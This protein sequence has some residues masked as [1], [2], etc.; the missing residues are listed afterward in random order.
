MVADPEKGIQRKNPGSHGPESGWWF[1]GKA[2]EGLA[3][4]EGTGKT[5]SIGDFGYV[6]GSEFEKFG[7]HG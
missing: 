2:F 6:L 5:K 7:G 1:A 3:E 4:V